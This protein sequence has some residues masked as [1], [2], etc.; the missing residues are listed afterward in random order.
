M[1]YKYTLWNGITFYADE[2]VGDAIIASYPERTGQ[3]TPHVES[4]IAIPVVESVDA[5]WT[6]PSDD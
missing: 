4:K 1:I 5:W 6:V 3:P 2:R